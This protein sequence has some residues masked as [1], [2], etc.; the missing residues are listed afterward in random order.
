[1]KP[2][3]K[4]SEIF[5][6][7]FLDVIC[8]GFGAMVLLVLLSKTDVASSVVDADAVRDLLGNIVVEQTRKASNEET[9]RQLTEQ[10]R[11]LEDAIANISVSSAG[12]DAMKARLAEQ[13]AQAQALQSQVDSLAR[14]QAPQSASDAVVKVGGIPV[15]S[16]YIIF[17]I[18][19]SGSMQTIWPRV[20]REL[21]NVLDIH[22]QV[23]GFQ[24]MN[25][26]GAYLIRSYA[27]RWIPDTPGRRK[28]V[29]AAL[30]N[31]YSFSDSNPVDGLEKALKTYVKRTEKLAIY[32]FGDDYSGG[33]YDPVLDTLTKLN[34]DAKSGE[35]AARIHGIGFFSPQVKPYKFAT[36][37]R[38]VTRR[39]RGAFVGIHLE[40]R[41]D[42]VEDNRPNPN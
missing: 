7:S 4:N 12:L 20:V 22:P 35:A 6:M 32:I 16:N 26:N 42:I 39:N 36:L 31:W 25:D 29:L 23:K 8:C 1:M 38:E 2:A 13:R 18:D 17:L 10:T 11:T 27:G 15:D 21:E 40:E 19:T 30:R 24:I 9:R 34:R 28:S 5:S 33:S 3:R 41:A 37:M 14:Q